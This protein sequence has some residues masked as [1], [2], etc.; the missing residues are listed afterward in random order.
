MQPGSLK[1][2]LQAPAKEL[3]LPDRSEPGSSTRQPPG[4]PEWL[5]R[6]WSVVPRMYVKHTTAMVKLTAGIAMDRTSV[7]ACMPRA[8][9]LLG[10]GGLGSQAA[11]LASEV[12]SKAGGLLGQFLRVEPDGH[13][14]LD[15]Q[16]FLGLGGQQVRG[17]GGP[18]GRGGLTER[19]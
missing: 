17:P 7:H 18:A 10:G 11:Q 8:G 2:L 6:H 12:L 14:H 9:G 4:M 19:V 5:S 13:V 16:S 1:Q 3:R 15:M